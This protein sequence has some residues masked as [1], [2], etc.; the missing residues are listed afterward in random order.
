[1]ITKQKYG[2][3]VFLV[4][5][6]IF[7]MAPA[8]AGYSQ[9]IEE[10]V[11]RYNRYSNSFLP[12]KGNAIACD[13]TGNVYVTGTTYNTGSCNDYLTLKYDSSGA[14]LWKSEYV[15]S[16]SIRGDD[17]AKAIAVDS[18]GNVYVTGNI[19]RDMMGNVYGTVKYDSAGV[20]VWDAQYDYIGGN[21]EASAIA[22]DSMGN[23][24]VT[25]SI[26]S[27][28]FLQYMP[29][30]NTMVQVRKFGLYFTQDRNVE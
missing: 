6:L 5:A 15:T 24:Y 1:M 21:N 4:Y 2:S 30:S 29:P 19:Y 23:V 9:A 16:L 22:V 3:M 28:C 14:L 10:W 18:A 12:D 7:A 26:D 8:K 25:G 11:A 13:A 27:P 20:Q 17:I